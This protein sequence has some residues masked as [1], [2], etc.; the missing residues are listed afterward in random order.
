MQRRVLLAT[1]IAGLTGLVGGCV[2][3]AAPSGP[4]NPPSEGD[5][6]SPDPTDPD[7]GPRS[8]RIGDWDFF[9]SDDGTLLVT[10]TV[11]NDGSSER[12]GTLVASVALDDET[13]EGTT[14]VTV[15][16]EETIDV[17]VPVAV[18]FERFDVAGSLWLDL[19]RADS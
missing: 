12:S 11:I 9:E 19:Q 8:F 2:D 15:P 5:A 17:E 3:A 6:T 13:V 10:A 14:D 4:R 16:P 7:E 18:S 1:G